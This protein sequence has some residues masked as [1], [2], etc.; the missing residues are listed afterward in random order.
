MDTSAAWVAYGE[1]AYGY[2]LFRE[3]VTAFDALRSTCVPAVGGP[4]W[5]VWANSNGFATAIQQKLGGAITL[6]TESC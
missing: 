3:A 5:V 4:T 6:V 2:G 1:A